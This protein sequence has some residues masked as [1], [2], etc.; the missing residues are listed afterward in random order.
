MSTG[1]F[2]KAFDE[3][4]ARQD[5]CVS[6]LAGISDPEEFVLRAKAR[7]VVLRKAGHESVAPNVILEMTPERIAALAAEWSEE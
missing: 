2:R 3:L 7:E 4:R 1:D 6:A 5:A